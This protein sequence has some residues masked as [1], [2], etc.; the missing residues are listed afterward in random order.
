[1][2][3]DL[4]KDNKEV[5]EIGHVMA[6]DG[7][8]AHWN[9]ETKSLEEIVQRLVEEIFKPSNLENARHKLEIVANTLNMVCRDEE[10]KLAFHACRN[11]S[12]A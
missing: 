2:S 6:L 12:E 3:Q 7:E 8:K 11:E 9:L 10:A 4:L 5:N 1:M